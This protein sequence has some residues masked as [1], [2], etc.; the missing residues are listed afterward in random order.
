MIL[1][2]AQ[3]EL[4]R[5]ARRV[6]AVP[7]PR[8]RTRDHGGRSRL[9]ARRDRRAERSAPP[10]D[11]EGKVTAV[12]GEPQRELD[13]DGRDARRAARPLGRLRRR[14]RGRRDRPDD[15]D[16]RDPRPRRRVGLRQ[17][18]RRE[19]RHADPAAAGAHR[20]R[21]GAVPRRG[22]DAPLARA[23][24]PLPLAERLD[25]LPERDERAEPGDAGRRP[26]RRHD[27]RAR[28]DLEAA[29]RSRRRASCSISSASTRAALRS[30]PHEL[31]GG[32]RQRVIIAMALALRPELVILD[33]PTTGAR[34]R[35]AARDPPA[36]ERPAA[37]V[38]LRGS[39]H[40]PRPLAAV[41]V[42]AP[43]RDHVRG[44]D[45][46]A[47]DR[48]SAAPDAAAPVHAG[49]DAFVPAAARTARADDRHPRLAA[50]PREP[51]DR[52]PL[53]S[54]LPALHARRRARSIA[55]QTTERP[56][57]RRG[58]AQRTTSPATWSRSSSDRDDHRAARG[59]RPDEALPGRQRADQPRAAA[60]RRR[61]HVRA[62]ARHDHRAR[63][64]ERQRQEHRRAPDRAP[65]QADRRAACSSKGPTPPRTRGGATCCGTARTS[66]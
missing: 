31:S 36:A 63:R 66:R 21:R 58:R 49:P 55:R 25:G 54:A 34:R 19:R 5:P 20:R 29:T 33:E 43:D 22:P 26:V 52:L 11:P 3:N 59:A 41:R 62:A 56:R 37:R 15:R 61:R 13:V 9:P 42:R 18:H 64:R 27:A 48:E 4:D 24:A 23:A 7:L 14:P 1:Y 10:Q 46:R 6:V 17:E 38:R 39:L 57:L 2:W 40:H 32:M 51:A 35:R 50:R 30:Y 60:R 16:E 28:A 8:T 12:V 65:L 53:P 47:D 45:R 44:R